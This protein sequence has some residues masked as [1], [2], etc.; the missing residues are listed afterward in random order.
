[1]SL[2]NKLTFISNQN[3]VKLGRAIQKTI[4]TLE[5]L[6]QMNSKWPAIYPSVQR[7]EPQP[8]KNDPRSALIHT[9]SSV[10][11]YTNG[12][13]SSE[14]RPSGLRRALTSVGEES[15]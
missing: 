4:E 12:L 11:S 1:M 13:E 5:D 6:R 2:L 8:S 14:L 3:R 9:Q 7:S 10:G 15:T